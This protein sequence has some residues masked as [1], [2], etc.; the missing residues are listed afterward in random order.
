MPHESELQVDGKV[1]SLTLQ[2]SSRKKT[3]NRRVYSFFEM[4]SNTGGLLDVVE[5][6][7][8]I[9]VL[10]FSARMFQLHQ[11]NNIF[12]MGPKHDHS[13]NETVKEHKQLLS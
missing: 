6:F 7:F 8:G 11:V 1:M 12:R 2:A 10:F 4:L 13:A 3:Y 5:R 9:F